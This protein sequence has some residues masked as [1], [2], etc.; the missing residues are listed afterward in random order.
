MGILIFLLGDIFAAVRDQSR[1]GELRCAFRAGMN[2]VAPARVFIPAR[3]YEA[4]SGLNRKEC[5]LPALTGIV[6]WRCGLSRRGDLSP[7][8]DTKP[9]QG[10]PARI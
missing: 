2:H 9:P 3:G 10:S 1:R 5:F 4:P 6:S 8:R 7:R